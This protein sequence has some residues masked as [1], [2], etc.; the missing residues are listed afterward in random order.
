MAKVREGAEQDS[1]CVRNAVTVGCH[2]ER[3]GTTW[4]SN[5]ENHAARSTVLTRNP[6]AAFDAGRVIRA[7]DSSST[8]H[9]PSLPLA[10]HLSLDLGE[11]GV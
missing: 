8:I 5:G 3:D 1:G 9:S 7:T 11:T 2:F 6:L 10:L 4:E